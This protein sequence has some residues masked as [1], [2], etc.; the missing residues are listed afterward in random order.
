[1]DPE[2][3]YIRSLKMKNWSHKS[4]HRFLKELEKQELIQTNKQYQ[5][6]FQ[7]KEGQNNG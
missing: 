5:E 4:Y 7:E 1:M 6:K 3:K 2:V